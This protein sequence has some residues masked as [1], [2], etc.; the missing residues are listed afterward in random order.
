[1][2][3]SWWFAMTVTCSDWQS[4]CGFSFLHAMPH[5]GMLSLETYALHDSRDRLPGCC[6]LDVPSS[7]SCV[8]HL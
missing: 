7:W 2:A 1:M 6:E 5:C 8:M 3:E 4:Y